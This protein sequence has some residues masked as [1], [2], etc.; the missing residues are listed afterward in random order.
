MPAFS[1]GNFPRYSVHFHEEIREHTDLHAEITH[2][3]HHLHAEISLVGVLFTCPIFPSFL[4]SFLSSF[5]YNSGT[6][7]DPKN[8]HSAPPLFFFLWSSP[9]GFV[10]S[11]NWTQ[12]LWEQ[13]VLLSAGHVSRSS[14]PV[15]MRENLI[16]LPGEPWAWQLFCISLPGSWHWRPLPLEPTLFWFI[17]LLVDFHIFMFQAYKMTWPCRI[18][19]TEL[20]EY[21]Q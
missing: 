18:Q 12:I 10:G 16:K 5:I 3:V 7:I 11:R 1:S 2:G 9:C 4:S 15:F 19:D 20:F 21:S 6:R 14:F 17:C 13:R 8:S